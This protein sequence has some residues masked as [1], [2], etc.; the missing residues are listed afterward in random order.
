MIKIEIGNFDRNEFL[1]RELK[2]KK[3]TDSDSSEKCA[4]KDQLDQAISIYGF[5]DIFAVDSL[6][7]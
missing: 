6:V 3:K 4:R 2:M 5:F 1:G 7:N